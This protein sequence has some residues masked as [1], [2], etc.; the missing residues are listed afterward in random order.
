MSEQYLRYGVARISVALIHNL[1]PQHVRG[2]KFFPNIPKSAFETVQFLQSI[3]DI[4]T[5]I[6]IKILQLRFKTII[7]HER[8]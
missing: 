4:Q 5:Y 3:L 2:R 7:P 6:F 1:K 8:K